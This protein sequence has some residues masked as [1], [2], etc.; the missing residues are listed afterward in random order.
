MRRPVFVAGRGAV[1]GFGAGLDALCEGIFSGQTALRTRRRTAAFR[2]ETEVCGEFPE[3]TICNVEEPERD[4]PLRAAIM[5]TEEA[6]AEAGQPDPM[7]IGVVLATTK[8]DMS[9]ICG[10]GAGL[11]SPMRLGVLVSQAFGFGA[12][13]TALSCACASGVLGLASA[14]RRIA[15]GECERLVVVAADAVNEFILRGFGG[16]GALDPGACRPFDQERRGVS[17]GDGA[18]AVVLTAHES[19]SVG[20]RISGYGGANDACHIT[21]PDYDGLGVGLAARRAVE[22]AGLK[23][24]DIDALQLHATG[25]RSNDSS[26]AIGLG[27]LWAEVA[28]ATPPAFGSKGQTGHTLGAAGVIESLLAIECLE[29]MTVP[30]NLGLRQSD[31]DQRLDVRGHARPLRR[32]RHALKVASG[33]G[34][35]QGAMVFSA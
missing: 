10:S 13:P 15:S 6:L 8:G 4:L 33:F 34:G 11:G 26:E 18:G 7:T 24:E 14:A 27:D 20:V 28:D 29:R 32:T 3:G 12:R 22:H 19:E 21:G 35:V 30:A 5:A 16:L 2:A 23:L 17:L 31:C 25:T 1:T 9:G